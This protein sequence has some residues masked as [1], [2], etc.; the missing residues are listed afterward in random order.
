MGIDCGKTCILQLFPP[1][2]ALELLPD[3]SGRKRG[4]FFKRGVSPSKVDLKSPIEGQYKP[5]QK[6]V[7]SY[8]VKLSP[9]CFVWAAPTL[10]TGASNN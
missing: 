4:T 2:T 5:F 8:Q 3:I 6:H 9:G 10:R 7:P 1:L